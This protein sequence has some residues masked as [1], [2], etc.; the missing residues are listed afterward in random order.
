[1][2]CNNS[3]PSCPRPHEPWT[4]ALCTPLHI[5]LAGCTTPAVMAAL[6]RKFE[7]I[8]QAKEF[9]RHERFR[10]ARQQRIWLSRDELGAYDRSIAKWMK[11]HG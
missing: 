8:E 11:K 7:T 3:F 6:R 1:M 9:I 5:R 10:M 2:D 4:Q